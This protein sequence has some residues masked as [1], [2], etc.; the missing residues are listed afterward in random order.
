MLK[1]IRT[2][3]I[4]VGSMGQNHARIYS[5]ISNL[6]AVSDV[7]KKQGL[8][9]SQRYSVDYFEDYTE[10][11]NGVDA[12]TIAVP[13]IYHKEVIKVV[14]EAGVHILVEKPLAPSLSD[15]NLIL[16]YLKS[17]NIIFT[18]GHIERHNPVVRYAKEEI[19]KGKWG[20]IITMSSKRVSLLP[21]RIKDVGV[22]FDLGIHDLDIIRYL[23]GSEVKS[24]KSLGGYSENKVMEDHASIIM[25]FKNGIK[26]MCEVSWLTPMK[27]RKLSITCSKAYVVLDFMEQTVD[28]FTSR[29][30]SKDYSNINKIKSI[31]EQTRAEINKEEPLKLEIADFL[32]VVSNFDDKN[33]SPLVTGFDG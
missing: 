2:G 22:I 10:M 20:K 31:V 9:I 24:I 5:E 23:S 18:V 13:T 17:S 14:A 28:V 30:D 6:I 33:L 1:N 32:N 12:V 27:V 15:A 21:E 26:G 3:V 7:D 16:S 4:G 25:E 11:L 29:F 19:E 8:K